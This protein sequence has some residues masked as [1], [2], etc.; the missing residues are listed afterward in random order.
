M[1]STI[2]STIALLSLLATQAPI[3]RPN[4][5]IIGQRSFSL[6]DRYSNK[7]V[8]DVFKDNILLDLAY[9]QGKVKDPS[10]INWTDVTRPFE[11][12]VTLQPNQVFAFHDGVLPEYKDKQVITTNAHFNSDEG[13]KSDGYLVA[14][15]VCHLASL[16]N[17]AARDA[18]LKVKN[19]TNHDF[20][21]IPDIPKQYGTAIYYMQDQADASEL[22]NLYVTNN[23]GK[24]ITLAFE[25]KDET[26]SVKVIEVN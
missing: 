12:N 7:F 11:Y 21:A 20:A 15:G 4:E 16:I 23:K 2:I 17:W 3:S 10:H 1:F 22:Q 9:L 14:D 5:Q 26:L 18:Q 6:N 8:S 13:F 24:P 25:Y 19:P